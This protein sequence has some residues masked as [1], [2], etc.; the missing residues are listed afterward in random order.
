MRLLEMHLLRI[1]LYSVFHYAFQTGGRIYFS[2]KVRRLMNSYQLVLRLHKIDFGCFPLLDEGAP[3]VY[4]GL[5][6]VV[7]NR[8]LLELVAHFN[9]L[10]T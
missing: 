8:R 2:R 9:A 7:L 10:L 3:K 5:H 1:Q 6:Q 4:V